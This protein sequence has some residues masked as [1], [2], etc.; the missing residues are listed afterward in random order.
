MASKE[1]KELD[2]IPHS[3]DDGNSIIGCGTAPMEDPLQQ[4]NVI[5]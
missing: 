5:I 1:R 4:N 2:H 3:G